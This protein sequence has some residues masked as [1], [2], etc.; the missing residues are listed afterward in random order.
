MAAVESTRSLAGQKAIKIGVQLK[1]LETEDKP[2]VKELCKKFFPIDYPEKWYN[3][4][5]SDKKYFALSA[6][7]RGLIVGVIIAEVKPRHAVNSDD[8]DILAS[9]SAPDSKVAYLLSLGVLDE[10]R[11]N[12]IGSLLMDS[13][14]TEVKGKDKSCIKAVYLHVLCSNIRAIQFYERR[15]FVLHKRIS[16]YYNIN[17]KIEDGF[18]YVRYINGGQPP[19]SVTEYMKHV[20][21]MLTKF[22]SCSTSHHHYHSRDKEPSS[23]ASKATSTAQ[24]PFAAPLPTSVHS[25]TSIVLNK[26]PKLLPSGL[27]KIS[28]IFSHIG[29]PV[30]GASVQ[31][32]QVNFNGVLTE[33][34]KPIS[35]TRPIT[36]YMKH[37][38][39]MLTKFNSCS[40]SH[41]HYHSRD[42]EPSSKASKVTSTA[43]TPFAAPLPT[44]VHSYTSIVL[45]KLPKLLPSGLPKI[46]SIFSHIGSPVK[47]ASVQ[48]DQTEGEEE[49]NKK[50]PSPLSSNYSSTEEG[51]LDVEKK[52]EVETEATGAVGS[53]VRL[54]AWETPVEANAQG[55]TE[56]FSL[57]HLA[58]SLSSSEEFHDSMSSLSQLHSLHDHDEV[59]DSL[60][61]SDFLHV[62]V[63]RLTTTIFDDSRE[64]THN[65]HSSS[66]K[67]PN[68]VKQ[69]PVSSL[70]SSTINQKLKIKAPF[71]AHNHK[72]GHHSSKNQSTGGL[73]SKQQNNSMSS[74]WS[75]TKKAV[76]VKS[77]LTKSLAR[78]KPASS[79]YLDDE[80]VLN[81]SSG[82][83][84]GDCGIRV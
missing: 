24:T 38:T 37:V 39:S 49:Q 48:P 70:I 11:E 76:R 61:E 64:Q 5:T 16:G 2:R 28:S 31:P 52:E 26:L 58:S 20:T 32:D 63:T 8:A 54:N 51:P 25:Y 45:N 59:S 3:D 29:S 83:E 19:W 22:N 9:N 81:S 57:A 7:Y 56:E 15:D 66:I 44:S 50:S 42:K 46:S 67:I 60:T 27:P 80:E 84:Q 14:I 68:A 71:H 78:I 77:A 47:G 62:P 65:K 10:Y 4:V 75:T 74:G 40:T 82:S 30:K 53:S 34:R 12:G 17:N 35:E 36:E 1:F 41:H 21:S 55:N 13:L 72:S 6:V 79:T 73:M 33:N 43:Q 69:N 23:K 18:C